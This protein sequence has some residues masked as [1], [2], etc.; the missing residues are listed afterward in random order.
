[1]RRNARTISGSCCSF[2]ATTPRISI[3]VR[4]LARSCSACV[5]NDGLRPGKKTTTE[6][7]QLFHN[8]KEQVCASSFICLPAKLTRPPAQVKTCGAMT[9]ANAAKDGK[10]EKTAAPVAA[11]TGKKIAGHSGGDGDPMVRLALSVL[12]FLI[13][14]AS[15]GQTHCRHQSWKDGQVAAHHM[16]ACGHACRY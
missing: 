6:V 10:V 7:F 4:R 1:M 11:G 3:P 8:F 5:F 16:S 12:L 9:K 13:G 14:N 15:T 2:T